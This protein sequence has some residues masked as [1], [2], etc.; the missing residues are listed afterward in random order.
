MPAGPLLSLYSTLVNSVVLWFVVAVVM[1]RLLDYDVTSLLTGLGFGGIIM[2]MALKNTL[3]DVIAFS[4][5]LMERPFKVREQLHLGHSA[6]EYLTTAPH[7]W[8]NLL[9]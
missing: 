2:G 5:I 4:V 6:T 7:R 1:L 9:S 8:A 3:S